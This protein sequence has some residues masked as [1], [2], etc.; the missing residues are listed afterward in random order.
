MIDEASIPSFAR[1][2]KFRHDDVRGQWVILAPE[3]ALVPDETAVEILKLIDGTAS[4]ANIVD[5]LTERFKAPRELISR[6]VV[7]L[8]NDLA[9]SF[10]LRV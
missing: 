2:V 3:R 10:V 8:M 9:R 1:G 5:Q 6:D 4:V 7:T